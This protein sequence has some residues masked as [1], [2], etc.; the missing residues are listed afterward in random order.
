MSRKLQCSCIG[1]W[2]THVLNMVSSPGLL[3]QSLLKWCSLTELR[4]TG[5]MWMT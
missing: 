2:F 3:Y 1:Q 5:V 4:Q